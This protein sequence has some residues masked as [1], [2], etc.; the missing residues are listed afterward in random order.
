VA[1]FEFFWDRVVPGG[2]VLM[3]DH[4]YRGY[5]D[6]KRALDA[7]AARRAV[8]ILSLPTGQGLVIKPASRV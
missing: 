1:A 3:D 2:L 7:A 5:E 4:S 6:Q 8:R